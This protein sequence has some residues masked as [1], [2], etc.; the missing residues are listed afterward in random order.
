MI[1]VNLLVLHTVYTVAH[2]AFLSGRDQCLV[3]CDKTSNHYPRPRAWYFFDI[4]SV[5]YFSPDE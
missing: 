1:S 5:G 2:R 3:C 4:E